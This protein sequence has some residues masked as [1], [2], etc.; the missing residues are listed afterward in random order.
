VLNTIIYFWLF[1]K[2]C[3]YLILILLFCIMRF[4]YFLIIIPSSIAWI[5]PYCLA[6][7]LLFTRLGSEVARLVYIYLL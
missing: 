3:T 4:S 2:C 1:V 5:S 6:A 7:A